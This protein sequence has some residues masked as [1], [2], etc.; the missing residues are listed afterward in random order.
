[1]L[2]KQKPENEETHNVLHTFYLNFLLLLLKMYWDLQAKFF[3]PVSYFWSESSMEA[4]ER[5]QEHLECWNVTGDPMWRK[6]ILVVSGTSETFLYFPQY[7]SVLTLRSMAWGKLFGMLCLLFWYQSISDASYAPFLWCHQNSL[8]DIRHSDGGRI[9][10]YKRVTE[11][12]ESQI[13]ILTHHPLVGCYQGMFS[14]S[15]WRFLAEIN[16][17][18]L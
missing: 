15:P 6:G 14:L 13:N 8:S 18:A 11:E 7:T 9:N 1:M 3:S 4:P 12:Q 10:A 16:P 17:T 5:K 2:D